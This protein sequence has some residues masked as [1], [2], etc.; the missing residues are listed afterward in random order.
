MRNKALVTSALAAVAVITLAG[1]ELDD[2]SQAQEGER[3]QNSYDN[4][5]S[6][7]PAETMDY[8]PTRE[9]IN[10]W[11]TTWE[12]EGKLAYVYIQLAEGTYGYF[13]MD[14]PPVS[15]CAMLTPSYD[16]IDR[17]GDG[18]NYDNYEVQAPGVDG[19]YYTG[20][21]SCSTY[22]GFD[23]ETGSYMEFTVQYQ[24]YFLFDQ[25]MELP[26]DLV[27]MGDAEL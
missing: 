16:F 25:P 11:I 4:L 12:E 15:M 10:R 9:S 2:S 17:D 1:C 23:A 13:V 26:G 6:N 22:Y 7:Q 20:E 21:G 5:V 18:D 27:A 24:P 19:A 14:G 8:S 3:R